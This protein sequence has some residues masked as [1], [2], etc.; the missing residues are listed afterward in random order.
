MKDFFNYNFRMNI[1]HE[2]CSCRFKSLGQHLNIT[3]ANFYANKGNQ[4][5]IRE[6]LVQSTQAESQMCHFG[7]ICAI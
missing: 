5:K 4:N 2:W 1:P 7:T 6:V 3:P